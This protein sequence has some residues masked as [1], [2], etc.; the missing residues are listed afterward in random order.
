MKTCRNCGTANAADDRFCANCG[1]VLPRDE[2]QP[3]PGTVER[4]SASQPETIA[5]QAPGQPS[6]DAPEPA[7]G[8]AE[9]SSPGHEPYAERGGG[10]DGQPPMGQYGR[11]PGAPPD[12]GQVG[13]YGQPPASAYG[14]PPP[15][16]YGQPN[17][18]YGQQQPSGQRS[19]DQ[20]GQQYGQPG[21]PYAQQQPPVGD[22]YGDSA[23]PWY[24]TGSTTG[25]PSFPPP[26]SR[27]RR[28]G[29]K[30][31]LLIIVGLILL[32]CIGTV[33][34][35]ATPYGGDQLER[36]GTWAAEESTKQAGGN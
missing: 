12:P 3:S 2:D 24:A 10:Y 1:A 5:A 11:P 8:K 6:S 33:I 27:R 26:T 32:V 20:S 17:D 25:S 16:P 19:Y 22:P 18:P 29:W 4:S 9:T 34:F 28:S 30:T 31:A 36:L 15:N 23:P 7:F 21:G 14:Q 35:A 13:S